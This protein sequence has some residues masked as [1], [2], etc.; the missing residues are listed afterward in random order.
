MASG[1]ALFVGALV[2]LGLL[3]WGLFFVALTTYTNYYLYVEAKKARAVISLPAAPPAPLLVADLTLVEEEF[4]APRAPV[5]A[6]PARVAV[7]VN[8]SSINWEAKDAEFQNYLT[9]NKSTSE[10][11]LYYER[12]CALAISEGGVS[13]LTYKPSYNFNP[14]FYKLIIFNG[15]KGYKDGGID[16]VFTPKD[17]RYK[18]YLIQC[19]GWARTKKI[20]S[21]TVH[22]LAGSVTDYNKVNRT[23]YKAAL[24]YSCS[25]DKEAEAAAKNLGVTLVRLPYPM[26]STRYPMIKIWRDDSSDRS[27]FKVAYP[28]DEDY[29]RIINVVEIVNDT[30][31]AKSSLTKWAA[32][33][34]A[35]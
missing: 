25:L 30:A 32:E 33:E 17:K 14:D 11:G 1:G 4:F 13:S 22:Q 10:I 18:G 3:S 28:T 12:W 26:W 19:K 8:D 16:L 24:F 9:K 31:A 27:I 23:S 15:L 5:A 35:L 7:Q 34:T 6:V 2:V 20:H 29:D 21:N